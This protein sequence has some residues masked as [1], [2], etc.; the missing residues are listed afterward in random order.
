M[1]KK[2][3]VKNFAIIDDISL[4]LE[5]GFT[6]LTGQTGASKSLNFLSFS[7]SIKFK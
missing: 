2:L 6:V 3:H 1:L 7:G 4:D 5:P